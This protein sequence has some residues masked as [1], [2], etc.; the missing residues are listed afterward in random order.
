MREKRRHILL[1]GKPGCGKTTIIRKL[2][3]GRSDAGGFYTSEI[4][5]GGKRTGFAIRS[6]NGREGILASVDIDSSV[7][8]GRYSVNLEDI[9]G[10]AVPSIEEA[11]E[12]PGITLIVI[13]EIASMEI[14]SPR[15][16]EAVMRALNSP[17]RVIGTIQ[18]KRLPFLDEIRRRKDVRIIRIEAS[19]RES[20]SEM[21]ENLLRENRR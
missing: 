21:L 20:I 12:D 11:I 18:E 8:V 10:I 4:R 16:A 6:L 3:Q 14:S 9:E 17:K 1:T 2:V 7:K 13:D 5:R 19:I 15:F